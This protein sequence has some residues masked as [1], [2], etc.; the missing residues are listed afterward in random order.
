MIF[1]KAMYKNELARCAGVSLET[2]KKY[3]N[4]IRDKFPEFSDYS[5]TCKLLTPIQVKILSE[6]YGIK[7]D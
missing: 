5:P 1:M 2:M 3:I 7:V 4:A 6:Y